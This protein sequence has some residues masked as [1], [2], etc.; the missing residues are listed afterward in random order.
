M[1]LAPLAPVAAPVI[2]DTVDDFDLAEDVDF[3]ST[4]TVREM[5]ELF[6]ARA[7]HYPSASPALKTEMDSRV[8][9]GQARSDPGEFLRFIAK[10]TNPH[11]LSFSWS[12][13]LTALANCARALSPSPLIHLVLSQNCVHCARA[14]NETLQRSF[15]P[16]GSS[17]GADLFQ[18]D[19]GQM[20]NFYE[21]C[22]S[23]KLQTVT[24]DTRDQQ[25][26][27]P[28]MKAIARSGEYACI[29]VPVAKADGKF[30]HAMNIVNAGPEA[31]GG[32]D[33]IFIVC[34]QSGKVFD[35]SNAD[36]TAAFCA[37]HMNTSSSE[38]STIYFTPPRGGNVPAEDHP[39]QPT[40][41][42]G[43]NPWPAQGALLA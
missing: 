17:A 14:V 20:G 33:R 40:P 30:G 38:P 39:A 21:I 36:D 13:L 26:Y 5:G 4:D 34:G 43:G 2:P 41:D 25:A 8:L 27:L 31:Q 23:D 42:G 6:D 37:R 19:R 9:A 11:Q 28:A 24:V 3:Q 29:S 7:M 18:V 32:A 1:T 12:N 15:D 22:G 10:N 16:Q 35:L